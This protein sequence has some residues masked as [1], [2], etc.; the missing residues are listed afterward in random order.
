MLDDVFRSA[1]RLQDRFS[2]RIG[3]G[4][5]DPHL[6]ETIPFLPHFVSGMSSFRSA[7]EVIENAVC[8]TVSLKKFSPHIVI[9]LVEIEDNRDV[10]SNLADAKRFVR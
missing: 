2:K 3:N 9:H 10:R 5:V 4:A 7:A 6:H 8:E 1:L